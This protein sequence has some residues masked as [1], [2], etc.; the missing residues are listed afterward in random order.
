MSKTDTEVAATLSTDKAA[1]GGGQ[2][3]SVIARQV[4]PTTD[5]RGKVQFRAGGTVAVV[6]TQDG[7]RHRD[8]SLVDGRPARGHHRRERQAAGPGPGGRYRVDDPA[9]QGM[10]GGRREPSAWTLTVTDNTS[11]LQSAGAAAFYLYL[12]SGATNPP[13]VFNVDDLWVGPSRP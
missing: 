12:S 3:L 6:L 1:T 5:Y 9:A 2:Y 7:R 13:T 10:E 4:G 8:G 11:G